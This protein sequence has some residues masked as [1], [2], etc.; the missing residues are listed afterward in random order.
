MICSIPDSLS[1]I[2]IYIRNM[3]KLGYLTSSTHSPRSFPLPTHTLFISE[4]FIY[5][6]IF[7][8][9]EINRRDRS[10]AIVWPNLPIFTPNW[11]KWG[12]KLPLLGHLLY[13]LE[14]IGLFPL[15]SWYPIYDFMIK[16]SYPL[17]SVI[18]YVWLNLP[19]LFPF[20]SPYLTKLWLICLES[21]IS[22]TPTI[23]LSYLG[24]L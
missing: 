11:Q 16:P 13:C 10:N 2:S 19:P 6:H 24:L 8:P 15:N 12:A 3:I 17:S 23:I 18:C 14:E 9:D 1:Y 20:I 4:Y 21:V 7:L 5:F 22:F